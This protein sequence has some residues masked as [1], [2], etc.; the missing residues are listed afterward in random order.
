MLF[1]SLEFSRPVAAGRGMLN[2]VHCPVLTGV[3]VAGAA[4]LAKP[5]A[6]AYFIFS[7]LS[8]RHEG[9]Y[10]LKFHLFEQ[11]K[12]KEDLDLNI[13]LSNMI[14]STSEN[15]QPPNSQEQMANRMYVYSEPFQVFS[16]KKFP[17]LQNS[18]QLSQQLAD[19]GIRVRIRRE[20]RQR[21]DKGRKGTGKYPED[22]QRSIRSLSHDRAGS[23]DGYAYPP[24]T[25]RPS[26]D[27]SA[28][29]SYGPSR[30]Q[31]FSQSTI[32][33]PITAVPSS[34]YSQPSYNPGEPISAA[35]A[36]P[37]NSQYSSPLSQHP[38]QSMPPPQLQRPAYA[39]PTPPP[40][41]PS[42]AS[43]I[44]PAPEPVRPQGGY[45]AVPSPAAKKRVL[46]KRDGDT[47]LA[48]K[49]RAR[50][51]LTPNV[52]TFSMDGRLSGGLGAKFPLAS[53]EDVIEADDDDDDG[54]HSDGSEDDILNLTHTYKRAAG[55]YAYVPRV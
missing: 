20:I 22:E 47:S 52:P 12:R 35:P 34:Q 48:L 2:T 36:D 7:D 11:N 32:S 41:L 6:A 25:R 50:P 51:S 13:P 24:D 42:I 26:V 45:Y 40:N 9:W 5:Y 55:G 21:T 19:Q 28:S 46:N 49:D 16:A 14:E 53:G 10:R 43:M 29:Q 31:S 54:S 37:W 44:N 4:Y 39:T 30:H 3:C 33:S 17:G 15:P 1:A 38:P 27:S 18:T 23:I 8:V